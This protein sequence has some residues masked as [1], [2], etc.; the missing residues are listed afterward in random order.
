[1]TRAARQG[2][3]TSPRWPRCGPSHPRPDPRVGAPDGPRAGR[4]IVR[5]GLQLLIATGRIMLV[6]PRLVTPARITLDRYSWMY[7][8]E[9]GMAVAL[10]AAWEADQPTD[11]DA[12]R[13]A[14]AGS[15]RQ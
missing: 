8:E 6:E 9:A 15:H 5:L 7:P 10:D 14:R 4:H 13:D 12:R 1:M 11:L 3:R 2:R